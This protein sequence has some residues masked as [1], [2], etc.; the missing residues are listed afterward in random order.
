MKTKTILATA[1]VCA[2]AF[3]T[4]EA[5]QVP[6]PTTAAEVPVRSPERP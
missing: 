2:L 5:Q 3:A 4:A 6:I 1:L